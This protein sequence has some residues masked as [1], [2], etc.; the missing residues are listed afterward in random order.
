MSNVLD[1]EW[2]YLIKQ[3]LESGISEEEIREFLQSFTNN[4]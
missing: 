1:S 3:A 2:E 4:K